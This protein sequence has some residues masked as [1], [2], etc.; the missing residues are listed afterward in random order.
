MKIGIEKYNAS[1]LISVIGISN[2]FGQ[3]GLGWISDRHWIKRI[4]L[5]SINNAMCGL[6]ESKEE[7]HIYIFIKNN[8]LSYRFNPK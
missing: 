5:Y 7:E 3:I 6:S 4:Y 8:F 2:I 1:F